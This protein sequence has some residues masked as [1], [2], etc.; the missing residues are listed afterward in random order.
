MGLAS[1]VDTGIPGRH[2]EVSQ[3]DFFKS[4]ET[5]GRRDQVV[6]AGQPGNTEGSWSHKTHQPE[7]E[8][9]QRRGPSR[10]NCRGKRPKLLETGRGFWP[11]L[12]VCTWVTIL[13]LSLPAG[14]GFGPGR[15][16]IHLID[17]SFRTHSATSSRKLVWI[18]SAGWNSLIS[19]PL[20]R[21]MP[22]QIR[23]PPA[24]LQVLTSPFY[25]I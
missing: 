15:Q 20:W 24:D 1:G 11:A 23:S 6:H 14:Q 16:S 25:L 8:A 21:S 22:F 10:T 7:G 2:T 9:A 5:A 19:K 18:P 12:V 17:M 4:L 13:P 3:G